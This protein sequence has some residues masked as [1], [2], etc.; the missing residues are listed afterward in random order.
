MHIISRLSSFALPQARS[1]LAGFSFFLVHCMQFPFMLLLSCILYF[2]CFSQ[3]N[4]KEGKVPFLAKGGEQCNQT[5]EGLCKASKSK[6]RMVVGRLLPPRPGGG[7]IGNQEW[8][9]GEK[10]KGEEAKT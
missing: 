8:K 10:G 3:K 4:R 2:F 7:A 9:E 1:Y 6:S 5:A